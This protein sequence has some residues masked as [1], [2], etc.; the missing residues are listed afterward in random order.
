MTP[1]SGLLG[2]VD[3]TMP[4]AEYLL[5]EGRNGGAHARY[6]GPKD[7][8]HLDASKAMREAR[9]RGD[10]HRETYGIHL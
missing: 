3:D 6:R 8:K 1:N 4:L 2:W 7:I 9:E 10:G 5:G